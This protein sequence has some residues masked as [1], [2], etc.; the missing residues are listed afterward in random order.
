MQVVLSEDSALPEGRAWVGQGS[1]SGFTTAGRG[2]SEPWGVFQSVWLKCSWGVGS[3][4][5]SGS[6]GE[7]LRGQPGPKGGV[8]VP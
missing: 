2:S 1:P 8:H 5:Q 6:A 3:A 4:P 7:V